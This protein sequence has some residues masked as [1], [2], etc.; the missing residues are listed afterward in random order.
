MTTTLWWLEYFPRGHDVDAAIYQPLHEVIATFT[1]IGWRVASFG[2]V[3]E[4]SA[5]TRRD[6]LERLRLRTLSTFA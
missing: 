1:A 2:A 4:P 6:M 3:T 5:G